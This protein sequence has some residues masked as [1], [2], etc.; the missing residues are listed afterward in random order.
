MKEKQ[1][2][3][4][5]NDIVEEQLLKKYEKLRRYCLFLTKNEWDGN[6]LAQ[7]TFVK[8]LNKYRNSSI[9]S[10]RLLQ[11]TAYHQWVDTTR[12]RKR[13][14]LLEEVEQSA[15]VD[16]MESSFIITELLLKNLTPKQAITFLLKEAFHYKSHEIAKIL[17]MSEG[18]VKSIVH[19]YKNRIE[20]G[21]LEE[22]S[23][24]IDSFWEEEETEWLSRLIN[25]SI[26]IQDPT[27]LIQAIPTIQ[28]LQSNAP[29]LNYSHRSTRIHTP[30]YGLRMAA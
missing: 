21:N 8:I 13:E 18:S 15:Y 7:E 10:T 9:I 22:E 6:D 3:V 11:K 4:A 27:V 26:R 1:R 19:R 30:H 14:D 17:Q 24:I 20:K 16:K 29:A 12:K 2:A 5:S 28:T 23:S 25:T